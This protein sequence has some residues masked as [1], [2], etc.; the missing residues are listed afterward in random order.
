MRGVCPPRPAAAVVL[1]PLVLHLPVLSVPDLLT[2][3]LT[4]LNAVGHAR[5][6]RTASVRPAGPRS[7]DLQVPSEV[8]APTGRRHGAPPAAQPG[9]RAG[10]R[11]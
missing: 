8:P 2:V 4:V 11:A 5:S 6:D 3:L 9:P 1:A 10:P 7:R